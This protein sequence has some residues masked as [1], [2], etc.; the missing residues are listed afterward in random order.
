MAYFHAF[1][2]LNWAQI[3]IGLG[4]AG[5]A[6]YLL[7]LR[8]HVEMRR[9]N[10]Q[11]P[12]M[13]GVTLPAIGFVSEPTRLVCAVSGLAIAYHLIVWVF[14]ESLTPVQLPRAYWWGML[15]G[16]G[17]AIVASIGLDRAESRRQG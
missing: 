13:M 11:N 5:I 17:L 10:E 1:T 16:A 8:R 7:A 12:P 14:P 3:L 15:A 6:I 9:P 2:P 4:V